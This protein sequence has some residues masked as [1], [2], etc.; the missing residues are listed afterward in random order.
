MAIEINI[1]GRNFLDEG[2]RI[3]D[4]L[5]IKNIVNAGA[6]PGVFLVRN[7]KPLV[8]DVLKVTE[9]ASKEVLRFEAYRL[10]KPL[11][12]TQS[13]L[14]FGSGDSFD[15]DVIRNLT[16]DEQVDRLVG[17]A[18]S[19]DSKRVVLVWPPEAELDDKGTIIDGSGIVAM[20]AAALASYPA[21]QPF[22]NLKFNG[23]YKL[24]YSNDYFN[25]AQLDRLSD[26][27]Y[28][29]LVQDAPG[30]QVYCR[31]QKTTSQGSIQEQEL[32]ITKA[33]DKF[34]SDIY[35]LVKEYIGKYNISQDLLTQINDVLNQYL[36][37][38][39]SIKAPYCGSLIISAN[40]PV[41]RAN[42][43][44]ANQDLVPGTIEISID[45]EVGY[46]ANYIPVK[47]FVR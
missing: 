30:A 38:A 9:I 21:Q 11:G 7:G 39:T 20:V 27:G 22:T 25:S 17:I 33:V 43:E 46:P 23:P 2:I 10:S 15:F 24:R 34:S 12:V 40:K 37:N 5:V 31:H 6:F 41:L 26:A 13:D 32:S 16:K 42:L 19:Y 3:G 47:V 1:P 4:I 18:K 28:F 36:F 8:Y 35:D 29:V 45:I 44:G 14:N